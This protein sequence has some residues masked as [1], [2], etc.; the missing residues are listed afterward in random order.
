[1]TSIAFIMAVLYGKEL[2]VI[3]GFRDK[4]GQYRAAQRL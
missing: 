1:M 4:T 3:S 2:S